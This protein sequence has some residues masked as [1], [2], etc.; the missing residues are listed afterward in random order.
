[1]AAVVEGLKAAAGCDEILHGG[2]L[3]LGD[4]GLRLRLRSLVLELLLVVGIGVRPQIPTGP[5]HA[6]AQTEEQVVVAELLPRE[7]V[8]R[9]GVVY[10]DPHFLEDAVQADADVIRVVVAVADQG[11]RPGAAGPLCLGGCQAKQAGPGGPGAAEQAPARDCVVHAVHSFRYPSVTRAVD[12]GT[13]RN[14]NSASLMGVPIT[15]ICLRSRVPTPSSSARRSVLSQVSN[16]AVPRSAM[17]SNPIIAMAT[18]SVVTQFVPAI[19]TPGLHG[20]P[21]RFH[22]PSPPAMVSIPSSMVRWTGR[23]ATRSA[24]HRGMREPPF[25]GL[26]GSFSASALLEGWRLP[27]CM[28]PVRPA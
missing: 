8:V 11:Q 12:R 2:S 20:R 5:D 4:P 17:G 16:G 27:L 22:G 28:I 21:S 13:S 23:A 7:L 6:I 24:I 14:L 10:G 9:D 26:D 3:L 1:M 19:S 18:A 25:R 15:S